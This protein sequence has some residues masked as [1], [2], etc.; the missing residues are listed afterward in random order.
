MVSEQTIIKSFTKKLEHLGI[1][2]ALIDMLGIVDLVNDR[3]PK[4]RHHK[5]THGEVVKA[6]I[7]NGLG[8][9]ER[10]L[11]LFS[12][13]F[14]NKSVERL[15]GKGIT[16]EDFSEDTVGRTLDAIKNYGPERLFQEI[17]SQL[18]LLEKLS[19]QIVH[20]D[21]TN[22]SVHG[23]Y[24]KSNDNSTI[25]IVKGHPKDGR[26]G[27]NRFG[28]GLVVNQTG[29]PLF[30][31][32]LSGNDSDKVT[33]PE[34]IQE[35]R[36]KVSFS[37]PLT[38]VADSA[39]FTEKNIK[40]IANDVKFVTLVPATIREQQDLLRQQALIFNQMSDERYTFHEHCS[41]YGD[42]S[43][44]W[45]MYHS[46][47]LHKTKEKTLETDC[48]AE[49]RE[50]IRAIRKLKNC[51]FACKEEAIKEA[52]RVIKTCP[53]YEFESIEIIPT[54]KKKNGSRGRPKKGDVLKP[55]Y[56]IVAH[57]KLKTAAW[58]DEQCAL[59]K[60]VLA[61]NDL[62]MS[63]EELL[64]IYKGQGVVERGFRFLKDKSFSI[65]DIY[66]KNKGRIESLGMLMT[67]MLAVYSL[68]EHKLRKRLAE[69]NV[70]VLNQLKKPTSKPTLK[71]VLT[72]FDGVVEFYEY[73]PKT[74][75]V[76]MKELLNMT[77]R[78]WDIVKLFGPEC[79]KYY[80]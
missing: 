30:M 43:Q 14:E 67:L 28:L 66:L 71:W 18:Y 25:S 42:V 44:K 69:L 27:L 31:K 72:F 7:I 49:N 12:D 8:F 10:R 26:W 23:K 70:T 68:G 19:R 63:A 38:C 74:N 47:S 20:I 40:I 79:E 65:S 32:M 51:E 36:K 55:C 62:D 37:E 75:S 52:T 22:F 13:Y 2:A 58:V 34:L 80:N 77:D 16:P 78:C 59:G 33:L 9:A 35:F 45:V 60:F 41:S 76:L 17:I 21:T 5:L 1:I 53:H 61:T 24:D 56:S 54:H 64:S 50:I 48:S 57:V 6:L 29:V 46:E 3:L 39:F 73:D 11:Y 4:Q 15:F